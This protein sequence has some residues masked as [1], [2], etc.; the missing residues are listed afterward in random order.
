MANLNFVVFTVKEEH[1]RQFFIII[2]GLFIINIIHADVSKKDLETLHTFIQ[3]KKPLAEIEASDV[4]KK[5]KSP[6]EKD[7]QLI[8]ER[9]QDREKQQEFFMF[10]NQKLMAIYRYIVNEIQTCEKNK[11]Y[12]HEIDLLETLYSFVRLHFLDVG[13]QSGILKKMAYPLFVNE[14]LTQSQKERLVGI[15]REKLLQLPVDKFT[16]IGAEYRGSKSQKV[17]FYVCS[18]I[19]SEFLIHVMESMLS[20]DSKDEIARDFK[21]RMKKLLEHYGLD[22][23]YDA[24]VYKDSFEFYLITK[25]PLYFHQANQKGCICDGVERVAVD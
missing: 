18:F 6:T 25:Q 9:P 24:R 3:E 23:V 13:L 20:D 15:C 1:M 11:D 12:D 10:H 14:D 2:A 17:K 7:I 5:L 8:K 19:S 16:F 21:E 4:W 22:G